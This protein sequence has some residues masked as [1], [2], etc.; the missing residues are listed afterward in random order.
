MMAMAMACRPKLLVLDEPT[1]ALDVTTQIEVLQAIKDV[2][3]EHGTA[4]VYVSHDLSVVAQVADRI[5][6]MNQGDVVERGTTNDILE[7]PGEAYTKTL[8]GAV[9][10]KPSRDTAIS[11][12]VPDASLEP[13]MTIR[14]VNATYER[15]GMFKTHL[16]ES[17][18]LHDNDL[19]VFPRKSSPWSVSPAAASRR[20]RA[21]LPACIPRLTAA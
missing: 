7:R 1:T 12:W 15:T 21:S 4:A 10:P 13:I 16:R 14:G 20:W 9:K 6:V 18:V 3:R 19:D 8:L 17:N 11:D 2:I 5:L